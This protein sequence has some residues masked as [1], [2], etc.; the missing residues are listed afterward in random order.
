[1]GAPW[2]NANTSFGLRASQTLQAWSYLET[3]QCTRD[4]S[5]TV[6]LKARQGGRPEDTYPPVAQVSLLAGLKAAART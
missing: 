1:M 4:V 2:F 3:R 5:P 6:E